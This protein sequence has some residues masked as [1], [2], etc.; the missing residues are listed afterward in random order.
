MATC[1]KYVTT[2]TTSPPPISPEL[3]NCD[4]NRAEGLCK[5]LDDSLWPP[6]LR[7]PNSLKGT[8]PY[9]SKNSRSQMSAPASFCPEIQATKCHHLEMPL[10]GEKP[11]ARASWSR[12]SHGTGNGRNTSMLILCVVPISLS[13]F[14]S[15]WNPALLEMLWHW[16]QAGSF[17][18]CYICG[19]RRE[20]KILCTLSYLE[21]CFTDNLIY[22]LGDWRSSWFIVNCSWYESHKT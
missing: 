17:G 11:D 9:I 12:S 2:R 6:P 1:L 4:G 3:L 13:P 21:W 19:T 20:K 10:Q 16:D 15:L 7:T 5:F 8:S 22:I 14:P 18:F